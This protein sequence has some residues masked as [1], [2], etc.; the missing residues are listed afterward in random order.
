MLH[1]RVPA[2]RIAR[3]ASLAAIAALLVDCAGPRGGAGSGSASG[4]GY[5]LDDGPGRAE[6]ADVALIADAVPRD[7]PI[8]LANSRPYEVFGTRYV[9]MRSRAPYRE[10]GVAS[11]YG[12]RFHGKP[13]A[14]GE[15]YDMYA[16]T[17]AHRTLP[18]PS[19]VR[20]TNLSNQRSVIVRVNDRG[21][22]MKNRLIDLSWTAAKKLDF[23][24]DGHARVLVEL[25]LPG[26][27]PAPQENIATAP[28]VAPAEGPAADVAPAAS[29][30]TVASAP[31]AATAT[32]AASGAAPAVEPPRV[33]RGFVLVGSASASEPPAAGARADEASS[34]G[35]VRVDAAAGQG[36]GAMTHVAVD[37]PTPAPRAPAHYLQLGAYESRDG[38][39]AALSDLG[40]RLA[41]LGD[42]LSIH[43]ENGQFKIHAGPWDDAMQARQ[44]AERI[45]EET[46]IEAFGVRREPGR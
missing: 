22:F 10:T 13:T 20:V 43:P 4:G 38:A 42:T 19:Y 1:E 7:E 6:P 40:R 18:L 37:A 16:M 15:P 9:P 12:R 21:P 35:F 17:A 27:G 36:A 8:R 2:R 31:A 45:R 46:R 39:A 44:V 14:S 5:Y 26:D 33:P 29:M 28:V 25:V 11:W 32:S 30:T 41:W 3:I 23:I 24:E 34:G